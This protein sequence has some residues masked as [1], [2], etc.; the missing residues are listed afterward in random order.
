MLKIPFLR[1]FIKFTNFL[2]YMC[3]GGGVCV[4]LKATLPLK[5]KKGPPPI[6]LENFYKYFRKNVKFGKKDKIL[7]IFFDKNF[8]SKF[9]TDYGGPCD[10]HK[11]VAKFF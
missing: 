5:F 10:Y 9:E 7:K 11:S 1:D 8:G 6:V 2:P 3:T 4:C